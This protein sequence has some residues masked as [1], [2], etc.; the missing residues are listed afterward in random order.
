MEATAWCEINDNDGC[1]YR[2]Q[3]NNI[4]GRAVRKIEKSCADWKF[5]GVGWHPKTGYRMLL[6]SRKF[7]T[8][9]EWIKWAKQFPYKLVE[10]NS[11]GIPK[12]I[13]FDTACSKK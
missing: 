11:K 9:E 8:R 3:V 6:Y 4:D 1:Q 10:L 12:P 5:F 13:K 7:K 2:L